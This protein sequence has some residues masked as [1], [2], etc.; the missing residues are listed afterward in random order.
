MRGDDD[1]QYKFRPQHII[2]EEL[3]MILQ[4]RAFR[5]TDYGV[6]DLPLSMFKSSVSDHVLVREIAFGPDSD[7]AVRGVG[8]WFNIE[9]KDLTVCT[10]QQAKRYRWRRSPNKHDSGIKTKSTT[11]T[12]FNKKECFMML[13]PLDQDA[14]HLTTEILAHRLEVL[15]AGCISNMSDR[16][17]AL[18]ALDE[19]NRRLQAVFENLRRHWLTWA[20]PAN[21]SLDEVFEETPAPTVNSFYNVSDEL[22]TSPESAVSRV[23]NSFVELEGKVSASSDLRNSSASRVEI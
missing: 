6:V 18:K 3:C 5:I 21:R 12:A 11:T 8:L 17:G 23:W 13:R 22:S 7:P 16:F 4:T 10:P 9:D 15:R 1:W 2:Y 19:E 14:Y 20:W